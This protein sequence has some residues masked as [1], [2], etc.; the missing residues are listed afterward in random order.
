MQTTIPHYH[1][2]QLMDYIP[3]T[4]IQ[5]KDGYNPLPTIR[6]PHIKQVKRMTHD[7]MLANF[8]SETTKETPSSGTDNEDKIPKIPPPPSEPPS[9]TPTQEKSSQL[10]SVILE[11]QLITQEQSSQV[12]PVISESPPTTTKN[13]CL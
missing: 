7:N 11:L 4:I 2:S 9:I 1:K 8:T 10:P 5:P 3:I 6:T 12:P 13:P